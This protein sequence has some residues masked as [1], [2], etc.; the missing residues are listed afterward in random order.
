MTT[1]TI[2]LS[3]EHW[4]TIKNTLLNLCVDGPYVSPVLSDACDAL[5]AALALPDWAIDRTDKY[6]VGAQL[7]TRD[8]RRVGN[9]VITHNHFPSP[10]PWEV[11]TDAGSSM[12][13]NEAELHELYWPPQYIMAVDTSPGVRARATRDP[14][15]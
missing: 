8:G 12:R 11:V 3:A 7:S 10:S 6:C 4:Q 14:G 9:A 5:D 1:R 15:F 2:T 13:L